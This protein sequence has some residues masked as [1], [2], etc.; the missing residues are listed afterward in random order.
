MNESAEATAASSDPALPES[1][2]AQQPM[3]VSADHPVKS[4]EESQ[5]E[6][7]VVPSDDAAKVSGVSAVTEPSVS[8][9]S[10]AGSSLV[11]TLQADSI[12]AETVAMYSNVASELVNKVNG[13]IRNQESAENNKFDTSSQPPNSS[14]S[15][16]MSYDDMSDEESGE[17]TEKEDEPANNF[18]ILRY[19]H[20]SSGSSSEDD[21]SSEDEN[22][23]AGSSGSE[24]DSDI[25]I[26]EEASTRK[27]EPLVAA[28]SAEAGPKVKERKG[29]D[30]RDPLMLDLLPPI[31]KLS[32]TVPEEDCVPIGKV[33]SIVDRLLV[34]ESLPET[35]PLMLDSVIFTREGSPIGQIFDIFGHVKRPFYSIRFNCPD[36]IKTLNVSIGRV[37]YCAPK[38]DHTKYVF[39]HDLLKEKGSDASWRDDTEV[40]VNCIEYSDDEAERAAK[41]KGGKMK[42]EKEA[43]SPARRRHLSFEQQMNRNNTLRNRAFK[44]DSQ[45]EARNNWDGG[46]HNY[47]KSNPQ[48]QQMSCDP[49]PPPP[50]QIQ[51]CVYSNPTVNPM[52]LVIRPPCF[53]PV[54]ER[55]PVGFQPPPSAF[56]MTPPPWARFEPPPTPPPRGFQGYSNS[57]P[58]NGGFQRFEPVQGSGFALSPFSPFTSSPPTS[59]PFQGFGSPSHY[60]PPP[61][62]FGP[63]PRFSSPP[64][65]PIPIQ[66]PPTSRFGPPSSCHPSLPL[67]PPPFSTNPF[68]SYHPPKPNNSNNPNNLQPRIPR[69]PFSSS[70]NNHPPL[71]NHPPF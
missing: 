36:D 6:E 62:G 46:W 53:N 11:A 48:F 32:I 8:A 25:E 22:T 15:L 58:T 4:P 60:G 27:V 26:V 63:T 67:P 64:P 21:R 20:I 9:S 33:Y 13:P 42:T 57:P 47:K 51:P 7:K 61:S 39:T 44:R 28:T 14:L 17:E 34:V 71:F 56:Q 59:N 70:N 49:P 55:P 18:S 65:P 68:P 52:N 38:T 2:N 37:V 69:L 3:Q 40:P 31:E 10:E 19:E 12:N 30:L 45:G 16:I 24:N 5:K 29:N 23:D 41:K 1:S 43:D 66:A 50:R 54:I 35:P